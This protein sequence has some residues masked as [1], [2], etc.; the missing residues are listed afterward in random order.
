MRLAATPSTQS[1]RPQTAAAEGACAQAARRRAA[2]APHRGA[3]VA[4][5]RCA[6]SP[7]APCRLAGESGKVIAV[8]KKGSKLTVEGINMQTKHVKPMKGALWP[9]LGLGLG[10]SSSLHARVREA[11]GC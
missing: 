6:L 1:G 3:H 7:R 9:S 2:H 4:P 10:T 11:C 5:S 8:D